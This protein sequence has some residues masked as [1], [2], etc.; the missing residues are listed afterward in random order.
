MTEAIHRRDATQKTLNEW[1][2]KPFKWGKVDCARMLVSHLRRFG[3]HPKISKAGEW[4]SPLS[5]KAALKRLGF[6]DMAE[7]ITGQGLEEIIPAFAIV[8]DVAL[9]EADHELGAVCVCVGPNQWLSLHEDAEGFTIV[10]IH[11]FIKAWRVAWLK[12]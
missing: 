8:G 3:Y 4:K 1:K 10:Q 6:A 2:D 12:H 9:I 7:A 5:A 11:E